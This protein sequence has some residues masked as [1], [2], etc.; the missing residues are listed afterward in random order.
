MIKISLT[1]KDRQD[2]HLAKKN[3]R[4]PEKRITAILLCDTGMPVQEIS[5]IIGL[6]S[7][8][9]RK[10]LR[11]YMQKGIKGLEM[12]YSPGR[13]SRTKT[14]LIPFLEECLKKDPSEY[15]WEKSTWDS[16]MIIDSFKKERG[17]KISHDSVSRAMKMLNY[18]YKKPQKSPS[19]KAPSKEEKIAKVEKI[20]TH[21]IHDMSEKDCEV[22]CSDESH[23]TNE[24]YLTKGYFKK[25]R[26]GA[27]PYSLQAG[28]AK[29]L[30]CIKSAQRGFLLAEY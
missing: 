23:F 22:F 18:S 16:K 24:P 21:I 13:P 19:I 25:G 28:D 20:I 8:S 11:A 14:M 30:W 29:S 3:S 26:E 27:H 15:G 5:K 1:D 10:H 7:A 6:N 2:L 4:I 17:E 9:T 12:N